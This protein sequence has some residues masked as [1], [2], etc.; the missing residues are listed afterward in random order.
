MNALLILDDD[1]MSES[2]TNARCVLVEA[3][4]GRGVQFPLHYAAA[5]G[6]VEMF[7]QEWE[8]L[9]KLEIRI[10]Q[11]QQGTQCSRVVH[12][13]LLYS[14]QSTN[15]YS[16]SCG[17]GVNRDLAYLAGQLLERRKR[18]Q[19]RILSSQKSAPP[20]LWA[21]SA[22]NMGIE[23]AFDNG[24][25]T[26]LHHA[27]VSLS[28]SLS[29]PIYIYIHIYIHTHIYI[30]IHI[31]ICIYT[32]IYACIYMHIYIHVYIYM[33]IYGC[34]VYLCVFVKCVIRMQ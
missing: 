24:G 11:Q 8:R 4:N 1:D 27:V 2:A 32:Y 13:Y 14:Y 28:P 17:A 33:H 31:Y 19:F 15:A 34:C 18:T 23:N 16:S 30:Y 25:W 20:P 26:S 22:S 10:L 6:D 7:K 21:Q 5:A 29:F 3:T 9:K 12:K